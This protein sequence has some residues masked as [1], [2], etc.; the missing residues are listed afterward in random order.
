MFRIWFPVDGFNSQ[1]LSRW[2]SQIS[3]TL[4]DHYHI[5]NFVEKSCAGGKSPSTHPSWCHVQKKALHQDNCIS[6]V[7]L[8]SPNIKW[9]SAEAASIFNTV[10]TFTYE[11]ELIVKMSFTTFFRRRL[12]GNTAEGQQQHCDSRTQHSFLCI[13]PRWLHVFNSTWHL[14]TGCIYSLMDAGWSKNTPWWGAA[15]HTWV[16]CVTGKLAAACSWWSI[17]LVRRTKRQRM[18]G[19]SVVMWPVL[20]VSVSI[21][22]INITLLW[23][24]LRSAWF[25]ALLKWDTKA[26]PGKLLALQ[27]PLMSLRMTVW[28]SVTAPACVCVA[29]CRPAWLPGLSAGVDKNKW[30]VLNWI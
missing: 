18:K 27:V 8:W 30:L 14:L 13:I 24:L 10:L 16:T 3:H 21:D 5:K 6:P 19:S 11:V 9:M 25:I 12:A 20:R 23:S 26:E 7:Q 2:P 15:Q 4:K 22:Q 29:L 28:V 1:Y 17:P